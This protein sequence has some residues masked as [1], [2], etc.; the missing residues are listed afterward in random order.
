[1]TQETVSLGLAF[2][3]G[4]VT[5]LSPC[6][7]PVLPLILG[8][9]IKSHPLGPVALVV[10]LVTGFAAAGSLLGLVSSSFAD[11]IGGLR[12]FTIFLL[13]SIGIISI[14]PQIGYWLLQHLPFNNVI[15]NMQHPTQVG[16]LGE[17]I[18]GNQL[19]LLWTPCAGP[20]LGSILI[21]ATVDKQPLGAFGLLLVYGLGAGLPMLLLAY[22]GRSASQ[23]LVKLRPYSMRLQQ[24]GG[25]VI[26]LTAIALLQGWDNDIQLWLAPLFPTFNI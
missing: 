7:L 6:V 18:L 10:G 23:Y 22:M 20:V 26:A 17:F 8:R 13:L 9:S 25:V 2:L 19:G 3:A 21:L 5:V 15:Q 16:L 24:V 14:F 11:F 4:T 1:M 12:Y